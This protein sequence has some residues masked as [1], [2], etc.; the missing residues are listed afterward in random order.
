[1]DNQD[2]NRANLEQI[3]SGRRRSISFTK[4]I[5]IQNCVDAH[6]HTTAIWFANQQ[7]P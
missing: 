1:M 7:E 6:K 5:G 2:P 3:A 4:N